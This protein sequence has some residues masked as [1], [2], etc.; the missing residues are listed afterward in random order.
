MAPGAGGLDEH[1]RGS[2]STDLFGSADAIV[3]HVLEVSVHGLCVGI[4][5][6]NHM[7]WGQ[8]S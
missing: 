1:L 5:E 4:H 6:K 3:K 7:W 2:G 8:T